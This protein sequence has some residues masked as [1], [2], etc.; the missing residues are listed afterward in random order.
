M[1][2]L[3]AAAS[4]TK[5]EA[6]GIPADGRIRITAAIAG[7]AAPAA[8]AAASGASPQAVRTDASAPQTRGVVVGSEAQTGLVL[9]RLDDASDTAPA[10]F[11]GAACITADRAADGTLSNFSTAQNYALTD[12]NAW[13]TGFH[14]A[15]TQSA[16]RT[17]WTISAGGTQD[18]L[19]TTE[20]WSAGRYT[21]PV[22]TGMVFDHVLACLKVNCTADALRP[23][24]AVQASWGKITKIELL[25]TADAATYTYADRTMA[26]SGS[27]ALALSQADCQTAFSAVTLDATNQLCA[28]GMFAPAVSG[29]APVKLKIY[30]EKKTSGVE[31]AVQLRDGAADKGFTAGMTHTVTLVF[32]AVSVRVASTVSTADWSVNGNTTGEI[33]TEP[34]VPPAAPALYDYYYSDGTTS[35]TFDASKTAEGIVYWIDSGYSSHFKVISL[36]DTHLMWSTS[37]FDVGTGTYADIRDGAATGTVNSVARVIGRANRELLGR[38]IADGAVNTTGKTIDDFPAFKYCDEMGS[39]GW[40]LPAVN[41]LQYLWCAYNAVS[42]VIWASSI[43]GAPSGNGTKQAA[44]VTLFSNAS[45]VFEPG[46]YMSSTE[47]NASCRWNVHF[48]NGDTNGNTSKTT[49]MGHLFVR[50]VK[51]VNYRSYPY[52]VEGK[53]VVSKDDFGAA[54]NIFHDAWTAATMPRH[55]LTSPY[56]AVSVRMEVAKEDCSPSN[57]PGLPW[58]PKTGTGAGAPQYQWADALEACARYTQAGGAKGTWRLMTEAEFITIRP[59]LPRYGNQLNA[60]NGFRWSDYG[61][62]WLSSET[63]ESA[64]RTGNTLLGYDRGQTSKTGYHLVRCVRDDVPNP[65]VTYPYVLDGAIIVS[66]DG[67]SQSAGPFHNNWTSSTI[68]T[69]NETSADN[70]LA[71]KLQVAKED[72]NSSNVPSIMESYPKGYSWTTAV[73]VCAAYTQSGTTPEQTAGNWRLPTRVEL[74]LIRAQKDKL[75]GVDGFISEFGGD[76]YISITENSGDNTKIWNVAFG[77]GNVWYSSKDLTFLVRCVRDI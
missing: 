6:P 34:S 49:N 15:G 32:D 37:E 54:A 63:S 24:G 31:V 43:D 56:N 61:W 68:P 39:G 2:I 20:A 40:Y 66:K 5:D 4:C 53:I 36:M 10:S 16:E 58:T 12:A 69:H 72:C 45:A 7:A 46:N 42:P 35:A 11:A 65:T 74:E 28:G 3:A 18:I 51:D 59:L 23:L 64:A 44:F 17:S 57:A 13:F 27:T 67:Y 62:Y 73:A 70:A 22:T 75:T 33:G 55:N 47:Y 21:A 60:I 1:L 48:A 19:L 50:C 8:S 26:F 77:S 52:V 76:Y 25:E 38:W 29:T 41:E 9:L 71:A 14:P 30:S